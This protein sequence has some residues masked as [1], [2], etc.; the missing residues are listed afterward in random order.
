M[1]TKVIK[2]HKMFIETENQEVIDIFINNFYSIYHKEEDCFLLDNLKVSDI[3][4]IITATFSVERDVDSD[5]NFSVGLIGFFS[6][7]YLHYLENIKRTK[8][9]VLDMP[10]VH[11]IFYSTII[12]M[13]ERGDGV[14]IVHNN[15]SGVPH[16]EISILHS[17]LESGVD[18]GES[19]SEPQIMAK[20]HSNVTK[21]SFCQKV[22]KAKHYI[23]E[24]DIFQVQI[25]RRITLN[26]KIE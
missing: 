7:E 5:I 20:K 10:D 2:N 21:Q 18:T 12:Q 15:L 9:N 23:E 14:T 1:P 19:K 6:Y 22:R 13:Q 11:L 24:G 3:F 26:E 8:R 4:P 16:R 25:G 17:I